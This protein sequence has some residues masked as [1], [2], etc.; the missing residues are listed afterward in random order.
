MSEKLETLKKKIAEAESKGTAIN[1][2]LFELRKQELVEQQQEEEILKKRTEQEK[3]ADQ[4]RKREMRRTMDM[5]ETLHV[6]SDIRLLQNIMHMMSCVQNEALLHFKKNAIEY[7]G[8][9]PAHVAM[10]DMKTPSSMFSEYRITN[11][12]DIGIEIEKLR[13][14]LKRRG[15]KKTKKAGANIELDVFAEDNN[16]LYVSWPTPFGK[17]R[18]RMGLIDTAGLPDSKVPALELPAVFYVNAKELLAFTK[19]ADDVSDHLSILA[20][21]DGKVSFFAEGD[22]D[23]VDYAPKLTMKE[24]NIP[25]NCKSLFSVDYFMSMV[26][27]MALFFDTII[28][29]IGN[30]NPLR[31]DGVTTDEMPMR[32]TMLLAPRIESE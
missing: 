30:D 10:I 11:E 13:K 22:I 26:Q 9:D 17:F 14:L 32:L 4:Q 3:L 5:N 16:G 31:M 24:Y 6:Q 29:Q 1:N 15:K 19:E 8:V 7:R 2:E 12:W 27:L 28:V 25:E 23:E 21:K 18:R 20:T